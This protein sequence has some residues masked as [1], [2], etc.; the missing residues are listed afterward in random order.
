M[1]VGRGGGAVNSAIIFKKGVE[2]KGLCFTDNKVY[3][4]LVY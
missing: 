3:D 1:N 2:P 4:I